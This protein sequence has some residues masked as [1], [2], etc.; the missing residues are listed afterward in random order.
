M[1]RRRVTREFELEVVKLV[2]TRGMKAASLPPTC[3]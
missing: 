2:R 1:D 3:R